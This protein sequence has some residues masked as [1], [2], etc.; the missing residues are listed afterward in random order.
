MKLQEHVIEETRRAAAE[1]F[2]YAT[3]VPDDRVEWKPLDHGRSVLD[4]A[5]ELAMT[6]DWAFDTLFVEGPQ[7]WSEEGMA[8]QT[9]E[10][11]SLKTVA[12]CEA[13]CLEH[14][15]RF[16]EGVRAMPDERL[17][18]TKWLRYEGGRD[19]TYAEML[20]YP[21][22]NFNYHLGQIAYIQTLYGDRDMY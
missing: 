12:A 3:K 1:V 7:D 14:L 13:R 22:W 4:L 10:M 6:P 17:A 8:A 2:R 20:D 16:Y 18:Q 11:E 9:A 19:F 5:R 21:R 15:E